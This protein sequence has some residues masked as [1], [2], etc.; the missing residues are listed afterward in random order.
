[1]TGYLCLREV[2][3]HTVA[4]Y[5]EPKL[6]IGQHMPGLTYII[7][8]LSTGFLHQLVFNIKKSYI[9]PLLH[10]L[11]T[12]GELYLTHTYV[13]MYIYQFVI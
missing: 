9:R 3:T 2:D 1:M 12:L 5:S 6:A 8:L 13:H 7:N 10:M 11:Q 4:Y